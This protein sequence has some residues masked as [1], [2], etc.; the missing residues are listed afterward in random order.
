MQGI[1]ECYPG[2]LA[3]RCDKVREQKQTPSLLT[4]FLLL[5]WVA[6]EGFISRFHDF[7]AFLVNERWRGKQ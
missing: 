1:S 4:S 6:R 5:L 3:W 7:V 2:V